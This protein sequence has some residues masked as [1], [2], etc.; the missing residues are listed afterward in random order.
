MAEA[1]PIMGAP[2]RASEITINGHREHIDEAQPYLDQVHGVLEMLAIGMRAEND[3]HI[4]PQ[5]AGSAIEGAR[6]LVHL[7]AIGLANEHRERKEL[8]ARIRQLEGTE[9]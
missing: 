7:A 1:A 8:V 6:T 4:H 3:F 5:I 2:E 9:Q